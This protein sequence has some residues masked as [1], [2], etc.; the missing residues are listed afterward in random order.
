MEILTT[1]HYDRIKELFKDSKCKIR[2][3]SPYLS[4]SLA[5]NLCELV[6]EKRIECQFITR[7]YLEDL[8]VKA[9]N[10][11]A[12]EL[13][14][15]SGI[16]VYALKFLHT[17]LYIFDDDRAVVGSANFTASGFKSNIEL[18]LLA[19]GK[20]E[21]QSLELISELKQYFDDTIS[22]IQ[23]GLVTDEMISKVR[24]DYKDIIIPQKKA[25]QSTDFN[26]NTKM[27][28]S[29]IENKKK[30]ETEEEIKKEVLSATKEKDIINEI[31]SSNEPREQIKYDHV[32]WMKQMGRGND[33]IDCNS[34]YNPTIVDLNGEKVMLSTY[35][36]KKKPTTVADGDE[37]YLAALSQNSME[38]N[39]P[40][41]IGRGYLKKFS[42]QNRYKDE[43]L[44]EY[45]WLKEY[46]WYCI[47][48]NCEILDTIVKNGISMDIVW[49][50]LGSDTYES[51]FGK[52]ETID[53]VATKHYQKA[54]IRLSGNA[55]MFIDEQFNNL[56]KQY[57]VK[58]YST[59][60]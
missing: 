48:E 3:M 52:C 60:E 45:P 2:I 22:K 10:I 33:R 41:I 16:Q 17:K 25:S 28:G 51:S 29:V 20:T 18:S 23:D 46:P 58:K 7:I 35:S 49:D 5:E 12:I 1:N 39:V 27:Y 54:H 14:V 38:Q 56:A 59:E 6:K 57:G 44:N 36:E 42:E 26:Y 34:P 4:K 21:E 32:I 19:D 9:N 37:I 8:Y 47:I 50:E 24:T 43:W 30:T 13:M 11:D 31:F 55:K 53:K 40:I 15:K